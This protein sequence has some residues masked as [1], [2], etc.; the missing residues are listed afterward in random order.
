MKVNFGAS[1]QE[2]INRLIETASRPYFFVH[3]NKCG[4]TSVARALDLFPFHADARNWRGRIGAANWNAIRTFSVVRHPYERVCSFYRYSIK[5]GEVASSTPLNE[6]VHTAFR[7]EGPDGPFSHTWRRS[8]TD[9]L[10]DDDGQPM[11]DLVLRLEELPEKWHVVQTMTGCKKMLPHENATTVDDSNGVTALTEQSLDLIDYVFAR[12]FE[13]FGY[14]RGRDMTAPAH[15]RILAPNRDW[16]RAAD[17]P[18]GDAEK[19]ADLMREKASFPCHQR[20]TPL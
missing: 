9:W 13:S 12:D 20:S 4:G 5:L 17:R 15:H 18:G 16:R 3:I 19:S 6:W 10:V 7:D 1:A 14:G 2:T 8:C 11:V